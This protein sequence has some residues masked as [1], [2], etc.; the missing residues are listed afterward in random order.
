MLKP[1]FT[2]IGNTTMIGRRAWTTVTGQR[3]IPADADPT[4][5]QVYI[6][7]SD[8]TPAA[9]YTYLVDDIRDH[10]AKA[11]PAPGSTRSCC[12]ATSR[13]V[14]SRRGLLAAPVLAQTDAAA[15]TG[16]RASASPG[17]PGIGTARRRTSPVHPGTEYTVSAWVKLPAGTT[18]SSGIHFTVQ[19]T[20]AAGPRTAANPAWVAPCRPARTAG[21]RSAA[22]LHAS[23]ADLG[24]DEWA[25]LKLVHRGAAIAGVHPSFLVEASVAGV[26]LLVDDVLITAP[27]SRTGR[28]GR[29]P[30][31][32]TPTSRGG[33][34]G[35]GPRDGGPGAPPSSCTL[36]DAAH[37]GA[38]SALVTDRPNQGAGI[39]HD[40]LGLLEAGAD[41]RGDG[42]GP[43][44][45][46]HS[47]E[48]ELG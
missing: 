18:G 20:N 8:L 28:A 31:S 48:I 41:V 37:G 39:G 13:P 10:D 27:G 11:D 34:D 24:A 26:D 44:R 32:S 46:G 43:L 30:S 9:P 22:T 1:A 2:W 17:A 15:H 38:Q 5:L 45:D 40:V 21:P 4:Q 35:W 7:T 29:R 23:T 3:T 6:G 16:T 42:L 33:L 36:T 25:K 19:E 12:R 47:R 14:R